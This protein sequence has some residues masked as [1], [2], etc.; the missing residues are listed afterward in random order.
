[1]WPVSE[2]TRSGWLIVIPA[3]TSA[4]DLAP[5]DGALTAVGIGFSCFT[6]EASLS[7]RSPWKEGCRMRPSWVYSVT[8]FAEKCWLDPVH[9]AP[10]SGAHA[11]GLVALQNRFCRLEFPK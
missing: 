11:F 10:L 3:A 1:M 8:D 9:A 6:S 5:L 7:S 4:P 2:T